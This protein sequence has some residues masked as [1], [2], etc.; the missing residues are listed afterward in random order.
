MRGPIL[1][2]DK[3]CVRKPQELRVQTPIPRFGFVGIHRKKHEG[4]ECDELDTNTWTFLHV[5]METRTPPDWVPAGPG[6]VYLC[7]VHY[8]W[9]DDYVNDM[10]Y[11]TIDPRDGRIYPCRH[12]ESC[13][14]E[15]PGPRG[16]RNRVHHLRWTESPGWMDPRPRWDADGNRIE[17]SPPMIS[18]IPWALDA[19][20]TID[21]H[22]RF[23]IT[24]QTKH[25]RNYPLRVIA[26]ISMDCAKRIFRN[27][28]R[29]PVT[30]THEG[31]RRPI[32]HWARAHHRKIYDE[33]TREPMNRIEAWLWRLFPKLKPKPEKVLRKVA[34]V[35]THTRGLQNFDLDGRTCSILMPGRD[36]TMSMESLLVGHR[37]KAES[38]QDGLIGDAAIDA[39]VSTDESLFKPR[40]YQPFKSWRAA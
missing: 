35:R 36:I 40:W 9:K 13:A 27:R 39:S 12:R 17:P 6:Y 33:I 29:T 19:E 10:T 4:K 20:Q 3:L 16:R 25:H 32:M 24:R 14:V 23:S 22:M 7:A 8:Y 15:L 34:N 21:Q 37:M 30:V 31:K 28:D 2:G 18:L 26:P 1:L 11:V 38:G 5:M